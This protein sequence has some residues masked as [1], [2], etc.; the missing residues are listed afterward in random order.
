MSFPE[1]PKKLLSEA[2]LSLWN[3]CKSHAVTYSFCSVPKRTGEIFFHTYSQPCSIPFVLCRISTEGLE[4]RMQVLLERRASQLPQC[5][6]SAV[7]HQQL[8]SPLQHTGWTKVVLIAVLLTRGWDSPASMDCSWWGAAK[9]SPI[10]TR[11]RYPKVPAVS[12]DVRILH[13]PTPHRLIC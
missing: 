5:Q 2:F 9:Q 4:S 13:A 1:Q 10:H 11:I 6:Q 8:T 12:L 3:W 7:P